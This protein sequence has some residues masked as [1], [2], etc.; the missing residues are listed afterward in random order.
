MFADRITGFKLHPVTLSKKQ[1]KMFND[2]NQNIGRSNVP[3]DEL[4]MD[5]PP[6][7]I[8]ME[9]TYDGTTVIKA[10]IF[11]SSAF[12]ILF[13]TLFWN[14]ITSVF[15]AFAIAMT[16]AKFGYDLGFGGEW[17]GSPPPLWFFWLF[18]SPFI[19]VGLFMIYLTLFKFLGKCV[20]HINAGEGS[21]F[22]GI[23]LLG[24]TQR[25]SPQSVKSVVI[26][27]T[28]YQVNGHALSQLTIK[29]NNGREIKFP[30]LDIM[31]ETWLAFA[32]RKILGTQQQGEQ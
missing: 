11:S 30:T 18:L 3:R 7:G 26:G 22:K 29:M 4:H 10:R 32:L 31:H 9:R 19:G 8:T 16:A 5:T 25:F 17:E 13:F 20:I 28:S 1:I 24:G 23:G 2:Y 6:R 27:E 14:A 12:G 15:V 21:L